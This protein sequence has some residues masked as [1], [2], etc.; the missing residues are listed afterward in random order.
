MKVSFCNEFT[1][2]KEL[3]FNRKAFSGKNLFYYNGKPM[4]KVGKNA[5]S[6]NNETDGS[7]RLYVIGNEFT[8]INIQ[9]DNHIL[10]VIRKLSAI[11]YILVLLPFLLFFLNG[12]LNGALSGALSGGC[13]G[14]AI[15][16]ICYIIRN[17]NNIII[18]TGVALAITGAAGGIWFVLNALLHGNL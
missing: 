5:Y 13:A 7:H 6:L 10:I 17:F 1:G 18:K 2:N 9:F 4:D 3:E 8:G 16:I 11:E 15:L 12:A 14:A